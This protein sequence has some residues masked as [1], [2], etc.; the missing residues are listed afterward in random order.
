M[1]LVP[2]VKATWSMQLTMLQAC[3]AF[4]LLCSSALLRRLHLMYMNM[5]TVYVISYVFTDAH[6]NAAGSAEGAGRGV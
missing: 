4:C 3:Y 2:I 5:I 6:V 1:R